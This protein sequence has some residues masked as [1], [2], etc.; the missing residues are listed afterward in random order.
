MFVFEL[1]MYVCKHIHM[2]ICM[3]VYMKEDMWLPSKKYS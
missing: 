2:Y 3:Y 1:S